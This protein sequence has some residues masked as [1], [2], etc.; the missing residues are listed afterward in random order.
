MTKAHATGP[1]AAYATV[2]AFSRGL[3]AA[4][5]GSIARFCFLLP[6]P[7]TGRSNDRWRRSAAGLAR[8]PLV[9]LASIAG[10]SWARLH[11]SAAIR[12]IADGGVMNSR[13]LMGRPFNLAPIS[14]RN[15]S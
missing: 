6:L 15:A 8:L 13:G 3:M 1:Q 14:T 9:V 2:D 11:L 4:A 7:A 5:A 10:G 12:S